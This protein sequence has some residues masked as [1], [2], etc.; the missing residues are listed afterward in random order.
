MSLYRSIS[1]T[2][3]K[4][5]GIDYARDTWPFVRDIDKRDTP[6]LNS[7]LCA[8]FEKKAR[9]AGR[10]E[11]YSLRQIEGI[12]MTVW[13][14]G[15]TGLSGT[16]G[17]KLPGYPWLRYKM[18]DP[19]PLMVPF[20][21]PDDSRDPDVA[22]KDSIGP[23]RFA[24]Y[25]LSSNATVV[26]VD[27]SRRITGNKVKSLPPEPC[28]TCGLA[29]TG[30]FCDS[31]MSFTSDFVPGGVCSFIMPHCPNGEA[32]DYRVAMNIMRETVRWPWGGARNQLD[33]RLWNVPQVRTSPADEDMWTL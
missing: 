22:W 6:T 26:F 23:S 24:E 4:P 33:P 19:I 28:V 31:Q 1:F 25:I 10:S 9:A 18:L 7:A 20:I 16:D 27:A 29:T 13:A 11:S 8:A 21:N 2:I 15:T 3:L 14:T 30:L 17:E 32:H 12:S 5:D